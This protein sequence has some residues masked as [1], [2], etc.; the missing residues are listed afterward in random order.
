MDMRDPI[1]LIRC[2]LLSAAFALG[3]CG[4]EMRSAQ[5]PHVQ[6]LAESYS[7]VQIRAAL[8]RAL[9]K[10]RFAIESEQDGR[11]L[12]RFQRGGE[13]VHV[14]IDYSTSQ[15][16]VRYLDSTGLGEKKDEAG[17]LM[18]DS[19]YDELVAKLDKGIS[20]ELKRPAKER[21]A[22]ERRALVAQAQANAVAQPQQDDG[23][24]AQ[25]DD[26]GTTDA[27]AAQGTTEQPTIVQNNMTVENVQNIKNV[28]RD[29]TINRLAP[30]VQPANHAS[31]TAGQ[32]PTKKKRDAH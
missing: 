5:A 2:L 23:Q 20:E 3:G 6:L 8:I 13:S 30:R 14:A 27:A 29:V 1:L 11:V 10:R 24:D 22:E 21:A 9:E 26:Q 15:F 7:T 19:R 18:V 16:D 28:R 31:R 32:R 17:T 12:A 4:H 25:G